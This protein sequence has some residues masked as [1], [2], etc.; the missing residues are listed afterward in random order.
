[1]LGSKFN[2]AM[3]VIFTVV[4]YFDFNLLIMLSNLGKPFLGQS[5]LLRFIFTAFCHL[6]IFCINKYIIAE[7]VNWCLRQETYFYR[8]F[9]SGT[10]ST[11]ASRDC[12]AHRQNTGEGLKC[13]NPAGCRNRD[14]TSSRENKLRNKSMLQLDDVI[15]RY[16]W[17][18]LL[19]ESNEVQRLELQASEGDHICQVDWT[20]L[21]IEHRVTKFSP[22]VK[23]GTVIPTPRG[24]V[25]T[26]TQWV[27]LVTCYY[28]NQ[29]NSIQS[30]TFRGSRDTTSWVDVDLKQF[31]TIN[32]EVC[33]KLNFPQY[34]Q[35]GIDN[36]VSLN[37]V[38]GEVFQKI[39][40]WELKSRVKVEPSS[41]AHAQLLA[42]QECSVVEFEIRTTLSN[43]KEAIPVTYRGINNN[44]SL[45][46]V[47]IENL[48]EAFRLVEEGGVLTPEEKACVEVVVE[49]WL[50][51]DGVEHSTSYP[52]IITRGTC[53]CVSWSDQKVDIKTSP[54]SMDE[55]ELNSFVVVR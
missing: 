37:K 45:F 5:T 47:N 1:M 13:G 35:V 3:G 2:L 29:V 51:E 18:K 33:A 50:D 39:H 53:V 7:F 11:L 38:K 17:Q 44:Q 6:L 20:A 40:T 55:K 22:K 12:S 42:R 48:H 49:R 10:S 15:Q 36:T 30:Y 16:A 54:L 21:T 34:L 24:D 52:Q 27:K 26:G 43:L 19:K 4:A 25:Q 9:T 8:T 32:N 14:L 46:K 31:Y 23:D 28:D 41:R